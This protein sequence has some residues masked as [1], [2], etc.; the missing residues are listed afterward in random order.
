MHDGLDNL[1]FAALALISPLKISSLC[2]HHLA[3]SVSLFPERLIY[4]DCPVIMHDAIGEPELH[5]IVLVVVFGVSI[6]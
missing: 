5:L 2:N 4:R 1:L 6:I 3:N